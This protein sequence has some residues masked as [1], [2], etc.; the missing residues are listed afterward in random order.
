MATTLARDIRRALRVVRFH[1]G[2]AA[3]VVLT[4]SIGIGAT[5]TTFSAVDR[6]LLRERSDRATVI[7]KGAKRPRDRYPR[8]AV[9]QPWHESDPSVVHRFART[10]SG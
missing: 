10:P 6:L 9:Q 7:L 5:V 8:G 2:F 3:M 4:I 1:P